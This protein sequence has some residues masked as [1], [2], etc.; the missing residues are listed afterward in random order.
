MASYIS[1]FQPD[2]LD[3]ASS[4]VERFIWGPAVRRIYVKQETLWK[5]RY[6]LKFDLQKKGDSVVGGFDLIGFKFGLLNT[7]YRYP[8]VFANFES[9]FLKD[10]SEWGNV[11]EFLVFLKR[12][13]RL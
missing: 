2:Y 11:V 5:S 4:I 3:Q 13:S 8:E 9:Y 6:S 10:K 1:L 7:D 12:Y